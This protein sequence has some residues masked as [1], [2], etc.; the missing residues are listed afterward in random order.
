VLWKR[1]KAKV[2]RAGTPQSTLP[3]IQNFFVFVMTAKSRHYRALS[4]GYYLRSVVLVKKDSHP[5]NVRGHL[6]IGSGVVMEQAEG[7]RQKQVIQFVLDPTK[8]T[9]IESFAV[10]REV[11][12]GAL[13]GRALGPRPEKHG[14]PD[15]GKM[16]QH[17]L[18]PLHGLSAQSVRVHDPAS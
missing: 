6:R 12:I 4:P 18:N 1:A 3:D 17:I 7:V 16:R 9:P 11:D 2:D 15:L 8:H 14:P 13:L 5:R 10:E